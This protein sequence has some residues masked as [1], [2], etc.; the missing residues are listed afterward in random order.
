MWKMRIWLLSCVVLILIGA[1]LIWRP[2]AGASAEGG[3]QEVAA[4][5]R[6]VADAIA[7]APINAVIPVVGLTDE[8]RSMLEKN[9]FVVVAE[10]VPFWR[11]DRFYDQCK[12][13]RQPIFVTSDSMLHVSHLVFD[14]YLRFLETAHLRSDLINLTDS[15]I[16][17]SMAYWDQSGSP[18]LKDAALRNATYFYVAKALLREVIG[19]PEAGT[20]TFMRSPAWERKSLSSALG[21]WTELKHDTVVYSKQ[22]YASA[23]MAFATMTK[24]GPLEKPKPVHGYVEPCPRIYAAIRAAV[25]QLHA[26]LL[27]L[28]F[29][30]DRGLESNLTTLEDL[31]GKLEGISSKELAGQPVTDDEQEWVIENFGRRLGYALRFAHYMDV[32]ENFRSEMD[33]FMPIV[34][35]VCTDVNSS[36]VLEEG[37]GYPLAIYVEVPVDGK[38]TICKGAV[39]SYYEFKQPMGDRLTDEAWRDMLKAGKNPGLPAWTDIYI[40]RASK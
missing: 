16:A 17:M 19:A 36:M 26:K 29:P 32:T 40:P 22:P 39:Y 3:K 8:A 11:I 24:G 18:L 34:A 6:P 30:P 10:K 37:V 14:W 28:G 5:D 33:Q 7:A 1:L 31:L 21:S 2:W 20:P 23:Q 38:P 27:N 15:G 13:E 12:E 35:D 9:G 25:A 4:P